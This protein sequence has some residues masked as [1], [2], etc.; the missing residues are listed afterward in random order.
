MYPLHAKGLPHAH[1]AIFCP[2]DATRHRRTTE[3]PE[4]RKG[5]KA[6]L[7]FGRYNKVHWEN[8]IMS[9]W[10]YFS[11]PP[12]SD[13]THA[14]IEVPFPRK[15]DEYLRKEKPGAKLEA[16]FHNEEDAKKRLAQDTDPNG[17]AL[18]KG[19]KT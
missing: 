6:A 12:G 18:G 5:S 17:D 15:P 10:A 13:A 1:R 3:P 19:G 9:N 14:Y 11:N 2:T 7:Y 4:S 16:V 8:L